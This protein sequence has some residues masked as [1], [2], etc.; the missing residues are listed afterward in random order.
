MS[1]LTFKQ[2]TKTFQDG[3]H[4]INALK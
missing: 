1:V 3:H 4:E 2:V